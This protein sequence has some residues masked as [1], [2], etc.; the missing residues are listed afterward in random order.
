MN[1]PA[2]PNLLDS[3]PLS[4]NFSTK[5]ENSI[6]KK[7]AVLTSGGDAPGMNP[8]VRAVVRYGISK[9]CEIYAVYEGYQGNTEHKLF[10]NHLCLFLL[11]TIFK[12]FL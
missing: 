7:I 9:G 11:G 2:Y 8:A 1:R 6:P 5:D 3:T 10:L 4:Q 12:R